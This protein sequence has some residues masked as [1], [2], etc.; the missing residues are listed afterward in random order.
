MHLVPFGMTVWNGS[1]L[2]I[3]GYQV[4]GVA[5]FPASDYSY[6]RIQLLFFLQIP[7][8]LTSRYGLLPSA[9]GDYIHLVP[10]A[11]G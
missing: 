11:V 5:V 4:V 8:V 1:L 9:I 10:V 2:A 7:A 3:Y 6:D